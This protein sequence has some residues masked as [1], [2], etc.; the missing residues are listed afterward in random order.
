MSTR[1]VDSS[2]TGLGNGTSWVNAWTTLA[3]V[4][5]VTAGDVVEISGGASGSSKTYSTT[6]NVSFP[7]LW[8]NVV[9]G[10]TYRIG[11]DVGHNGT[12]IF[13][14]GGGDYIL[15]QNWDDVTISGDAGDG[16]RHF[17][18]QNATR[19]GS[20]N[21][22]NGTRITYCDFSAITGGANG[23]LIQFN[24]ATSFEIDHCYFRGAHATLDSIMFGSFSSPAG[25]IRVHHNLV[26]VPYGDTAGFG[27]DGIQFSGSGWAVEDNDIRGYHTSSWVGGQHQ[28]GIQSLT[29]S[30]FSISRNRFTNLQNYA[31]YLEAYPDEGGF[32]DG[33]VANNIA[34]CPP[35]VATQAFAV[36]GSATDP[37][38]RMVVG[39]NVADG[40]SNPF[41]F[42]N[43]VTNPLPSAFVDCRF[44]NN[45]S[46]NGG[47]NIIDPTVDSD[48]NTSLTEEEAATELVRFIEDATDNNYAPRTGSALLGGGTDLSAFYSDDITGATR[49]LWSIGAYDSIFMGDAL[50]LNQT[51]NTDPVAEVWYERNVGTGSFAHVVRRH[52]GPYPSQPVNGYERPVAWGKN[53]AWVYVFRDEGQDDE[54]FIADSL[55]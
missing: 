11:Q 12:A 49:S 39:N 31:V 28:D 2:A 5:G 45:L 17:V 24:P 32:T 8:A 52:S 18:F 29:A 14:G 7:G 43:P 46:V 33:I 22:W 26:E 36:S 6:T 15:F 35:G 48:T 50:T 55:S 1:Y 10:V 13:D 34:I 47:S 54:T 23:T 4:T 42:R 9:D 53:N 41:T 37:C 3:A 30:D 16:E 19:V 38:T 20:G 40:F 25:S 44:A 51:A 21:G 27:A